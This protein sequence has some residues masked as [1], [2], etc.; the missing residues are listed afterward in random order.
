M[1]IALFG[2]VY[3]GFCPLE[4]G[5]VASHEGRHSVMVRGSALS[6]APHHD[7]IGFYSEPCGYSQHY[8]YSVH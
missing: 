1:P 3:L 7:N 8:V 6:L 5:A 2:G 4:L